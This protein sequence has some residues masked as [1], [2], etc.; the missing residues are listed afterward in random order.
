MEV[1]FTDPTS[2]AFLPPRHDIESDDDG[3]DAHSAHARLDA[4]SPP[5]SVHLPDD[6]A[7]RPLVVLVGRLAFR[8]GHGIGADISPQG[9]I[10][11]QTETQPKQLVSAQ[12][13]RSASSVSLA[14]LIYLCRCY[15]SLRPSRQTTA[16]QGRTLT[17]P[18]NSL[19]R[20][21]P[22]FIDT[23]TPSS[24]SSSRRTFLTPLK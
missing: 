5:L 13:N 21:W 1:P 17:Y 19:L 7:A 9:S 10:S 20:S 8:F 4:P 6:F 15:R 22:R 24:C 14:T 16:G 18:W 11:Q 2:L 23:G 3:V 12:A